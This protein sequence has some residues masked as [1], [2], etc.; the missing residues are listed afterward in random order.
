MSWTSGDVR[1]SAVANRTTPPGLDSLALRLTFCPHRAFFIPGRTLASPSLTPGGSRMPES[2]PVESVR[3]VCSNAHPYRDIE[4][5]GFFVAF[6][7][8]N[9]AAAELRGTAATARSYSRFRA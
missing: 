6:A 4:R 7:W 8:L 5:S 2:G 9:V 1:L 3:G